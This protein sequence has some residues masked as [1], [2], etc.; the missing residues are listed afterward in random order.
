M[1]KLLFILLFSL[2]T[3]FANAQKGIEELTGHKIDSLQRSHVD[4]I[5]HYSSYCGECD[6]KGNKHTCYLKSGYLVAD[7]LIIYKQYRKFYILAFDCY[8]SD[9]KR[10]PDNCKSLPYFLTI[11]PALNAQDKFFKDQWKKGLFPRPSIADGGFEEAEI[12]I[13]KKYI[14][15]WLNLKKQICETQTNPIIGLI[16]K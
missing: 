13:N 10:Q 12:I 2:C 4:T 3:H 14:Y 11:I 16:K 15:Q 9:T 8:N 5:L 1:N 6:V 7:N